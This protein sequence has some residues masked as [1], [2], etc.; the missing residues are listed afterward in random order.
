MKNLRN[1]L[2]MVLVLST[3]LFTSCKDD[4]DDVEVSHFSLMTEHMVSAS[5]DLPNI[6]GSGDTKFVTAAPATEAEIT[7]W[8]A[9]WHIM[10]IRGANDFATGHITGAKNVPFT[11]ILDEAAVATK[12]ILIV[13]YSGQSACYATS[14]LRLAG[15]GS[16]KALKWGMSGWN[17]ASA[18]HNSGW[19][20]GVGDH[21]DGNA[22]WVSTA[23]P[24]N[25]TFNHPSFSAT[26]VDGPSIL[27]ERVAAVIAAGFKGVAG[28]T[29]LANPDEYHI[30]NYFNETDYS[31]FGHMNGAFRIQPLTVANDEIKYLSNEDKVVTY[32]YTGQ[33]SAVISAYLNVLGYDA[34]S[35]KNGMNGINNHS[36]VWTTGANAS[37]NAKNQWKDTKPMEY[38]TIP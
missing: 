5:L 13:C 26:A 11:G 21:V 12:P 24:S 23:A 38:P 18:N 31:E 33:T 34:V 1:Y 2:M 30:N 22:N 17:S 8:A 32:C 19:N 4:G 27:R 15:Y 25:V 10:D 35:M 28:T 20:N 29:V 36:T 14:L 3:V 9:G 16:T 37:G 7:N 6:I